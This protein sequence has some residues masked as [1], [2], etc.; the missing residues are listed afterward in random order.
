MGA[1]KGC[2]VSKP[3]TI[4][5]AA[6]GAWARADTNPSALTMKALAGLDWQKHKLIAI[7]FSVLTEEL[8]RTIEAA[9]AEHQ[10]DIW[11]GICLASGSMVMQAEMVATNWRDFDV[12]DNAGIK[13]SCQLIIKNGPAAY[14]ATIPN[15]KIVHAMRKSGIPSAVSYSAG[16]HLCNQMLY[17]VNHL[18]AQNG[19]EMLCGFLHVPYTPEHIVDH[20]PAHEPQP[21]MP[22][23][24]MVEGARIAICT[25][26]DECED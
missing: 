9:L 5:V 8:F 25:I 15:Q 3:K 20:L 7:E 19:G 11:L 21:S 6:Y 10:P 16:T 24:M 4:I 23:E 2:I 18:N 22:L 12:P 26:L 14:N 13:L 1:E 17:T